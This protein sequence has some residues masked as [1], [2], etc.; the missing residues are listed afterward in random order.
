MGENGIFAYYNYFTFF[1]GVVGFTLSA[2]CFD[3]VRS[4]EF[5]DPHY[6]TSDEL[7]KPTPPV[8][9]RVGIDGKESAA[10]SSLV[11]A[12]ER[13]SDVGIRAETD[14]VGE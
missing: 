14:M 4:F 2:R 12:P 9:K 11:T 1:P 6:E 13:Y 7:T 5:Y 8:G 3:V 10:T